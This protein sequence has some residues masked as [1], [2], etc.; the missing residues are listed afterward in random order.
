MIT[1]WMGN[2]GWA[3]GVIAFIFIAVFGFIGWCK[4]R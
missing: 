2:N 4:S 3:A 1:Q